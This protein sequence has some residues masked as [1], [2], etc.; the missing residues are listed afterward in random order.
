MASCRSEVA[1]APDAQLW[2]VVRGFS[3]TEL[4]EIQSSIRHFFRPNDFAL[5]SIWEDP[6]SANN[7]AIPLQL[8][9]KAQRVR[10]DDFVHVFL[11]L[12]HRQVQLH[13]DAR[14][15][16]D[17]ATSAAQD[18][19]PANMAASDNNM[20]TVATFDEEFPQ[21]TSNAGAKTTKRRITTT[22]LTPKDSTVVARP[23][24][25]AISFPPLGA[26]ESTRPPVWAKHSL[27]EKRMGAAPPSSSSTAAPSAWRPKPSMATAN[28]VTTPVLVNKSQQEPVVMNKKMATLRPQQLQVRK[29]PTSN[30]VNMQQESPQQNS[31]VKLVSNQEQDPAAPTIVTKKTIAPSEIKAKAAISSADCQV[32]NQAAK[33]YGFLIRER[34][35][36]STCAELQV[37]ISLLY[38]GDCTSC[39]D[40]KSSEFC[41][42]THCLDFAELV[43]QEIEPVLNHLGADLLG[44]VKH[45]LR[46][47]EGICQDMLERLDCESRRREE[48]RVAESARIGCQLPVEMKASAVQDF[49]LPF[50]EETDS[51]LHYRT[52]AESLLYTNREKV[53]D[54]FLSLLRQ[55]QQKQHSLVG[56]EN[57]GV[58]AAAIAAARE[59]LA[60][61]SPE[62]R[63][64]FA[65]FF[66]QELVQIGSNPFGESDK[67]LV[68]KIMEDKLVVKNPDRLR[69]LHRRFSSQKPVNKSPQPNHR[70]GGKANNSLRKN[71]QDVK[72]SSNEDDATKTL[73]ATLERMKAYF[74]DNQLFFFHFLHSCDSYEFSE[75]VKH[76]LERQFYAIS[77]STDARKDFTEV[78][79]RLKVVAKFLGYL[80]FS[81]QWQV[82]SSIRKLSAQNAAFKAVER[83]GIR[84]LEVARDSS[85]DVKKLLED[86]IRNVAISKCIPWLCDYL[87]MLSLDRLSSG[88]TY[89]KQLMVLLQLLYRSP[90]LNSL[91][92]TGLYIA[93]QI[94]RIFH[95]LRLDGGFLHSS[96]YQS[97]DLLPSSD[98]REALARDEASEATGEDRLPFLYSQVFVQS[99]VSELDDLR[100]F[101]QTRAQPIPRRKL[102]IGSGSTAAGQPVTPIRKLRPLQVVIEDDNGVETASS[103]AVKHGDAVHDALSAVKLPTTRLS[104]KFPPVQEENDKLS[105][106]VFKVHPK[107]KAVVEFVVGTVTTD[108]CEHV[109]THVV[110][111]RADV[112]VD[113][114]AF[115]SGLLPGRGR[116][117]SVLGEDAA[118]AARASFQMLITSKTRHEANAAVLAALE[119]ALCLG[120]ERV[121]TAV[122]PFLPPSSHPTLT[123]SIVYVALQRT[124]GALKTLVPKSSQTEFVKRV[125]FRNKSLLK[126]LGSAS[127]AAALTLTSQSQPAPN[128]E[129][130]RSSHAE[131]HSRELRRLG[132]EMSRN[133]RQQ[134]HRSPSLAEWEAQTATILQCVS[135]FSSSFNECVSAG[136]LTRDAASPLRV[137]ALVLWDVVWR[138]VT[139]CLKVLASSL[140]VFATCELLSMKNDR[141]ETVEKTLVEFVTGFSTLLEVIVRSVPDDEIAVSRVQS[142]LAFVMDCVM[143]L[144]SSVSGGDVL[145]ERFAVRMSSLVV[146]N[147]GAAM[148]SKDGDKCRVELNWDQWK[149]PRDSS[150]L[151]SELSP[152]RRDVWD[153]ATQA[154]TTAM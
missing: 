51:R 18:S 131:Q 135:Q 60:D 128:Q 153:A 100:G 2:E 25:A 121:R 154:T 124:R 61:V 17:A 129:E 123:N 98:I 90:R 101:I 64:W 147:L 82:T 62:N 145:V 35:V 34:F 151:E 3:D 109:V 50:N 89:F 56:I 43:F 84:T 117:A 91:G 5:F 45:S 93:M 152:F 122:P 72:T 76:Q 143:E 12:L 44:L 112:L 102:S 113:R 83:E 85:L 144:P 99:C 9:G 130:L 16:G 139:S 73:T 57:A 48:L 132:A 13:A 87:S 116:T 95:V 70:A 120:E 71:R 52:P 33:L 67:D 19:N 7:A 134:G 79:L 97:K 58:A 65:K 92:E 11:D 10:V 55:F 108:V 36:K 105:D 29:K 88:T 30:Q 114:C 133:A 111:P 68:L 118:F 107:L 31:R 150:S 39:S 78:V 141:V 96:D 32:N 42:R 115:E 119:E 63:W 74:T 22:L 1:D 110:T 81:P 53:R 38:R 77:P 46:D 142:M 137:S 106:A 37:L 21:L 23:V 59:L 66:V 146:A 49:A 24:P 127:K 47:A 6:S 103:F 4:R 41:W 136:D 27:L 15:S 94:E 138:A 75:L 14:V 149:E 28:P 126:D 148:K 8:G 54:G 80:R 125:A 20:A 26:S 40:N 86:S 69:K 140:D 104:S